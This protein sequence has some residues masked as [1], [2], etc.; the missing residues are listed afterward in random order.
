MVYLILSPIYISILIMTEEL[1]TQATNKKK[2]MLEKLQ[3]L[4]KIAI[5]L[6]K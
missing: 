1:N 5:K 4:Q 3:N 2:A 6:V